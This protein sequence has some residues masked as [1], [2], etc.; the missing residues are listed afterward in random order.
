MTASAKL[1]RQNLKKVHK[2]R[3]RPLRVLEYLDNSAVFEK[4]PVEVKEGFVISDRD[5][6]DIFLT[7][8]FRCLTKKQLS[9]LHIRVLLY[10]DRLCVPYLKSDYVYSWEDGTFGIRTVG[11]IQ[12]K[13]KECN[14]IQHIE[15]GELFGEGVY[16]PI[17]DTYFTKMQVELMDVTYADGSTEELH[18]IAGSKALHFYELS[19][20]L[21]DIYQEVNIF[22]AAEELHPI[23]V[24]PQVGANVWLC[25]CGHKNPTD[26]SACEECGRDREWQVENLSVEKLT[27]KHEEELRTSGRRVLHDTTA[28]KPKMLENQQDIE[29][30]VQK[31]NEVM[32]TLAIREKERESRPV[33]IFWKIVLLIAAIAALYF[34]IRVLLNYLQEFGYFRSGSS[35]TVSRAAAVIPHIFRF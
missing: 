1:R 14:L 29:R 34:G 5:N 3:M 25:C 8:I 6:G 7:L 9:A 2:D 33:K 20:D 22:R 10:K 15:N 21:Q 23:R 31:C 30:K 12:R 17:P 13:D 32:E 26:A 28:Y 35:E 19:D 27:E 18:L 4:S 24:L 11:E 16:L